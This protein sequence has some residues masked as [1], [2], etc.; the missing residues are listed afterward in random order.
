[1]PYIICCRLGEDGQPLPD[2]AGKALAERAHHV[3]ELR[4]TPGLAVDPD[5]YLAHQVCA[6]L[7]GSKG[8][9]CMRP[10]DGCC[11]A[12][13]CCLAPQCLVGLASAVLRFT[14]GCTPVA[15]SPC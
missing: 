4:T 8:R 1:M 7:L 10:C 6:Q 5:Y 14:V 12:S 2:S 11:I 3:E 15:R 9:W 13:S